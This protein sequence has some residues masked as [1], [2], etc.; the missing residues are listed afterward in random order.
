[1]G[2]ACVVVGDEEGK[3]DEILF[4]GGVRGGVTVGTELRV[5][6]EAAVVAVVNWERRGTG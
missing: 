2:A 6:A 3:E 5:E 1:V 4:G